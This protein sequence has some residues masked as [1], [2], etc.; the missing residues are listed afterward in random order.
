MYVSV[1]LVNLIGTIADITEGRVEYYHNGV[2]G[3]VCDDGWTREEA[4]VVCRQLGF[5]KGVPAINLQFGAGPGVIWLDDVDCTGSEVR[6]SE[7]THVPWGE[8]DCSHREDVGVI[9]GEY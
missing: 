7:C 8:H 4:S 5:A 2:W 1:R 9:C 3:T 6:L